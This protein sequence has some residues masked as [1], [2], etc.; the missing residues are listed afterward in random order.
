MLAV[1]QK[2][3]LYTRHRLISTWPRNLQEI[4][5]FLTLLKPFQFADKTVSVTLFGERLAF[6]PNKIDFSKICSRPNFLIFISRII[7]FTIFTKSCL[8]YAEPDWE[9]RSLLILNHL[10]INDS[11]LRRR[12]R[13]T[14]WSPV[15]FNKLRLFHRNQISILS[16]KPWHTLCPF[17]HLTRYITLRSSLYVLY[18]P[19]DAYYS[20]YYSGVL[21]H[22]LSVIYF[23]SGG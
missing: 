7:F 1:L 21:L 3:L 22:I 18:R 11:I 13:S 16:S 20:H 12:Y 6:S 15:H 9:F 2:L 10:L 14:W 19:T 17:H 8:S 5:E 4:S 23:F